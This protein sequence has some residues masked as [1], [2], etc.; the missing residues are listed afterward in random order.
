MNYELRFKKE[1]LMSFNAQNDN[2]AWKIL[3]RAG[4]R[5]RSKLL[6]L[7]RINDK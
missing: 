1:K 3:T 6:D 7:V 4:I 2:I 5:N